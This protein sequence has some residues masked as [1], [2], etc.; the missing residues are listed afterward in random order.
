MHLLHLEDSPTD[1]ELIALLIRREW[2]ACDIRHVATVTEY[3]DAL[4]NGGFDLIL[5]D[6][7]LP[8]FDGLSAL[9]MARAHF[10]E[11]PFLFLSGTIGEERAVEALKRGA[12]DYIIKDRPTRLIP[13][14]RQAFALVIEADRRRRTEEAL[15]ENEE[16]FRQITEN[17]VELIALLDLNASRIYANPSYRDLL[18]E[19]AMTPGLDAFGEVHPDDRGRVRAAFSQVVRTGATQGCE[20]RLLLP[21]G[22]VRELESHASV[23]RDAAARIVNVLFVSRDVTSRRE[24][25]ARLREQAS[26]LD[27]ARDAIVATDLDHRIFYWN[28][29]AERL[30]GWKAGEVFGH[31]LDLLEIGF[32]PTRFAAARAQLLATGEWRGDFR[33]QTKSRETVLVESTWSLV[34]ENDGRPRSILYIDTDVTERKKLETQLLR[35]QRMESIGTLAGGVAHDLNNVLTPILLT[36]ELLASKM[37]TEEDRGLIEKARASATHGA[38]LVQQLLAFARGADAKRIRLDPGVALADLRSLIRQS[39]PPSIELSLTTCDAPQV[40]QADAT[41][42]NQVLINL[43]INA[44][45]AMP[46]GGKIRMVTKNVT[47]D[48]ALARVNPGSK[49]GPFVR[50]SII[51]SGM[52]IAPAI[53]DKIFDPFYT[54]KAAGKGTG[55]G[56]SMVAGI[57]KSHGGFVQVESEPGRGATFHLY[58]P[59]IPEPKLTVTEDTPAPAQGEGEGILLIDDEPI[60][61]DTLQLLL[62]RAGYRVFP[63]GDGRSGVNEFDRRKN[64][65]SL[66]ITDMMLPDQVGTEVVRSL[67]KRHAKLPI[68]AMSGM[69]GSGAFDELLSL[70]PP[71]ECLAKPLSPSA[72]LHAVRQRLPMREAKV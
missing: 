54:T 28:A 27:R 33:L 17:V 29:S 61:R 51:D 64:E 57:L 34:V 43:C 12:N 66:V 13:A 44:R 46:H 36:I 40:I 23:L 5:S 4:A 20:Y 48:E 8:G 65:I 69:M 15:R 53:I 52:G 19:A 31:R 26:L 3:R 56:L 1:A 49:P 47:V 41:Q 24:T 42:F 7:S 32:D 35:A 16:R 50:I 10:P 68:I 25:E 60:V 22:S 30:Y 11:T 21:D 6:Y 59:G 67:R 63:V 45:D 62:Q 70:N 2:P 71:V 9:S 18:G 14:I 58:F 39:L 38:A 55:L 37:T 72:L